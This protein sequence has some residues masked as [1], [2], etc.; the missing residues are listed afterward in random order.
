MVRSPCSRCGILFL[1]RLLRFIACLSNTVRTLVA[2]KY[3]GERQAV[4]FH[5]QVLDSNDFPGL[6]AEL[7]GPLGLRFHLVHQLLPNLPYHSL[8]TDHRRLIAA[9]PPTVLFGRASTAP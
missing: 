2:H 7:W 4:E 9:I 8:R 3:T 5:E 1:S 6:L